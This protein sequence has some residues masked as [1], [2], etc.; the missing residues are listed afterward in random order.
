MTRSHSCL[1]GKGARLKL[2]RVSAWSLTL[3]HRQCLPSETPPAGRMHLSSTAALAGNMTACSLPCLWRMQHAQLVIVRAEHA[4]RS[5]PGCC[6]VGDSQ[7]VGVCRGACLYQGQGVCQLKLLGPTCIPCAAL[8]CFCTSASDSQTCTLG[9]E[10][11]VDMHAACQCSATSLLKPGTRGTLRSM[12]G[13]PAQC[14]YPAYL[15]RMLM[16]LY[17][18]GLCPVAFAGKGHSRLHSFFADHCRHCHR[19][20]AMLLRDC[21]VQHARACLCE[22]LLFRIARARL[23]QQ[24]S[25]TLQSA[26]TASRV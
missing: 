12:L 18:S 10:V 24:L 4:T 21:Y 13:V 6:E 16:G 3:P 1:T 2:C 23:W 11:E 5:T 14:C 26:A 15:M 20:P 7:P 19:S 9:L 17:S 8:R 22:Q 25:S